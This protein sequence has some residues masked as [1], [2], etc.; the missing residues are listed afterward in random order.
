MAQFTTSPQPWALVNSLPGPCLGPHGS[1]CLGDAPPP[2]TSDG[3]PPTVEY[4]S[5][6]AAVTQ[7]HPLGASTAGF[8]FSFWRP[9]RETAV[10]HQGWPLLRGESAPGSRPRPALAVGG[11]RSAS[12][13]SA[14]RVGLSLC[15]SVPFLQGHQIYWI[16]CP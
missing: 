1:G 16:R 13:Q 7:P 10:G 2:W 15:P 14:L 9:E 11:S 4:L 5:P 12:P 8:L 6:A 3:V